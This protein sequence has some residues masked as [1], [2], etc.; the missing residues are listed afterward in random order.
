MHTVILCGGKGTRLGEL[1]RNTRPKPMIEIGTQP[2]LEHIMRYYFSF[3][4]KNFILCAGYLSWEIKNYFRTLQERHCDLTLDF[5]D[6]KKTVHPNSDVPD[7]QVTIAETG[8]NTMTAG[9]VKRIL[10][11][12]PEAD[13]FMLTYG[14]GVADVDLD[15]LVVFHNS[16]GKGLTLTGVIP[17]GRFGELVLEG[18]RIAEWAEKPQQSDRYINGGF[19]VMRRDFAERYIVPCDDTVMLERGPFEQ[20]SQDGEMMLYR[21]NGFWQCMDTFR[22]W[23]LLNRIWDEGNAPWV[24]HG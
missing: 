24:N 10:Q 11:Y 22:D 19:M 14:D 23:E 4:H 3:G 20:A 12:L 21:H 6:G 18:D 5:A 7:W 16:H 9:R 15:A 1:T 2:I 8:L 13:S 17:P